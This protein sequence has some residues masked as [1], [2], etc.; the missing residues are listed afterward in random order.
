MEEG[1]C[2]GGLT[3]ST[4]IEAC[5]SSVP[6]TYE[7]GGGTLPHATSQ[8]LPCPSSSIL[9]PSWHPPFGVADPPPDPEYRVPRARPS[10]LQ[11]GSAGPELLTTATARQKAP[12]APS[13]TSCVQTYRHSYLGS[14]LLTP[15]ANPPDTH[16]HT[17]RSLSL[18]T[19]HQL[20][21]FLPAGI[22]RG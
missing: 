5:P 20:A 12:L 19:S 3:H 8:L 2:G 7:H 14:L 1:Q 16:T 9:A 4:A 13:I 6:P 21:R 15:A 11:K 10:G 18:S 17:C 22:G